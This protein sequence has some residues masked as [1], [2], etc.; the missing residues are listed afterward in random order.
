LIILLRFSARF[1]KRRFANAA[2]TV[3]PPRAIFIAPLDGL[4]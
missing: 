2:V 4:C 1:R 3:P